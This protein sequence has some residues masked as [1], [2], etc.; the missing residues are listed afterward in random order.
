MSTPNTPVALKELDIPGRTGPV[1]QTPL[2]W[3]INRGALLNNFPLQGLLCRAGPWG[4]MN[5]GDILRIF[6][7]TNVQVGL[8][9]VSKDEVNTELQMFVEAKH[10]LEGVHDISYAVTRLG[11]T[12][13][14]SEVM[15][16]LV[17][18]TRPGGPDTTADPG[19]P[20]LVMSIPEEIL[21]GGIDEDNVGAGVAITI[22]KAD[23]APPYLFASAGDK[24]QLMWGGIFLP[25]TTLTQEQ[26][27]GKTPIIVEVDEATIRKAGDSDVAGIAVA[28]EVYDCVDN[29]SEDWSLEQRVAVK[30]NIVRLGAPILKEAVNN[31]LDVDKLG[32]AHGTSQIVAINLSSSIDFAV[33][34]TPVLRIR[35]TPREG[36]PI[37]LQ[38]RGEALV[39]VPSIPEINIPNAVLRE[40]AQSQITVSYILEKADGSDDRES[41]AQFI[42][43]IGEIHRLAAP[44]ALD[45]KQGAIDPLDPDLKQVTIEIAFASVFAIGQAIKLFWLG[46]RPDLSPYLPNLNLRPITQG[47][48]DAQLPLQIIVDMQHLTP[49]I[50]GKLELYYQLLIDDS[51]LGTMTQLNQ[52]HAI[53][54]SIHADILQ[55]GEPRKELPEPKVDGVVDGVLPA[56]T[57]STTLTVEYLKTFKDDIVTRFWEGSITGVDSD[58]VKLSTFTAGEPVPFPI[59]GELIKGNEGGTVEARYHIVRAAG[60][61]S[62][63]DTLKF[64]VGVALENPLPLPQMPQT[65]G[66]GASVTL[67]PLDAQ[68]GARVV[69]TFTGMNETHSIKLVMTGTPGAGSPDIP[70]KPGVISGGVEFLIPAEAIAANIGNTAQTFTLEYEVTTGTGEIPSET[71]TVTVTPLPAAELDKLNIVEAEGDEL[72]LSKVTA[73]ATFR[74]GV[75]AFIKSGQPVWAELKGKTAQGAAHDRAIWTVP[76]SSVNQT[77]INAGKFDRAVPFSYLKELGHDTYLEI[78][79]KVALTLSQVEEEAIAGPVKRYRVKA[80]EDVVPIIDSVKGSSRNED[81]PAGGYTVETAI[82]LSGTATPDTK[83]DLANNGT[84]MPNTEIEV[85]SKGEWTFTLTALIAG[86][87]YSLSARRKDGT[88][89]NTWNIVVVASVVPTLDNVLDDRNVEVLEGTI[90]VSTDLI[91]KGTASLGQK[92]NIRD[93]TG[94]GSATRGTATADLTKGIWVC[95]IKVPLGA[96]RLYAEACYPSNPLYSNVRNL[97]VTENIAPTIDSVIGTV[98][99]KEIPEGSETVETTVILSGEA[100]KGQKIAVLDGSDYLGEEFADTKSGAWEM[101]APNLDFGLRVFTA[102]ACYGN[103]DSSQSWKIIIVNNIDIEDFEQ[104]DDQQEIEPGI[105]ISTPLIALSWRTLTNQKTAKMRI[106]KLI[107]PAPTK[108]IWIHGAPYYLDSTTCIITISLNKACSLL[109][110][111]YESDLPVVAKVEFYNDSES[112]LG[113]LNILKGIDTLAFAGTN[114]KQVKISA[115]IQRHLAIKRMTMTY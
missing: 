105:S 15:K 14:P 113:S 56:D 38:V 90:T 57:N 76:G 71:L 28:F 79:F 102:N 1:S 42:N 110:I 45:A 77:W 20:G 60:G 65:T 85:D 3:G 73:G 55:I 43:A 96:R 88:L 40:L 87:T 37:D 101:T 86:T 84:L 112:Y 109:Q 115:D 68:T 21:K 74:A 69:V 83:I 78:V 32:D 93:G 54:E 26:A 70:A 104:F 80:V 36:P 67:A 18:I 66:N 114:I 48:M 12:E 53:R 95:P 22:S 27:E 11:Q 4:T 49:I 10:L 2:I 59:K 19:H 46:T 41:R 92:I 24:I 111:A 7:A 75:W 9:I 25:I 81:I 23:G 17:K 6:L 64:S 50:G 51:V 13:E 100:A 16:V 82:F 30:L 97:T 33:G 8:E 91:L 47:D 63:S 72:D 58:W 62:Y 39:S 52:T 108:A 31:V 34:D 35:G 61:T 99:G 44:V 103:A 29:R 89:S 98:S 5:I 107:Y 106:Q 94:S